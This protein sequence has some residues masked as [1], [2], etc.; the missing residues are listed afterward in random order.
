MY[1][2]H[3][4][5]YILLIIVIIILI[6]AAYIKAKF[7]F[8]AIQPV[9][10]VYD[11]K[12]Y[13]FGK[14]VIMKELPEKNKY[15]NFKNIETLTYGKNIED[16]QIT[17]FLHFI[18]LHYLQNKE[19]KFIPK[20]ENITPYFEGHSNPCYLSFYNE[21][22]LLVDSK[23]GSIIND[24]KIKSVMTGRPIHVVININ[25]FDSHIF[26]AYYIDY[27]CVDKNNRKSGIA[28]QVIQTHEYNA[29]HFNK[30][31]QVSIFKRE[32]ELTGIVPLCVY[33]TYGFRMNGW[34][35][36]IDLPANYNLVECGPNNLHHLL[37]F[38]KKETTK[39]DIIMTTE[40]TNLM[41]LIKTKNIFVYL[42]ICEDNV[43]CAY[44]YR[45]TNTFIEEGIE[46]LC[47]FASIKDSDLDNEKFIQ[48]FK[49]A[50]WKICE[51]SKT[52]RFA[53]VEDISHNNAIIENLKIRTTPSVVCPCAYFF[54]NFAY[55]TFHCSKVLI[56]N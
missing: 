11:L 29:R 31:I 50:L 4:L 7:K 39:F 49:V 38:M 24:K 17:K 46:G 30:K 23:E 1:W 40:I 41:E 16:H 36:P 26:D 18:I 54:Y 33:N 8:W 55:H 20:K 3:C 21:D 35:Q 14:G 19:N 45:K 37:D 32:G 2:Y 47:C 25:N 34:T 28:P 48:G 43:E 5:L 15:C 53:V 22:E 52:L 27:L 9:F 42:V 10:H 51:N 13:F 44:F 56:V 6:V 12:Y